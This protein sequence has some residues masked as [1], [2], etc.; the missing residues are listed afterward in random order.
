MSPRRK[1]RHHR[2]DDIIAHFCVHHLGFYICTR[3]MAVIWPEQKVAALRT[4]LE[5]EWLPI[6][7]YKTIRPKS[8][9]DIAI[10][11]GHIRSGCLV[12]PLGNF[13]SIRLTQLLTTE[14]SKA[15]VKQTTNKNWWSKHTIH[16]SNNILPDI[17][18]LYNMLGKTVEDQVVSAWTRPIGCIVPR[19]PTGHILSDAAYTGLGGWSPNYKFM[20]RLTKADL[21]SCGF[22]MQ[23]IREFESEPAFFN[24]KG[25][26]INLL[27]FV[28]IAINLWLAIWFI[29][30]DP[31]KPGGHVLLIEAD[32]TSALSW[33]RHS[34][35]CHSIPVR[36]RL[37]R[38]YI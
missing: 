15:G 22:N 21:E 26:H 19:D 31:N 28:A 24:E 4:L 35:R 8:P 25:L 16:I 30:K 10:L 11:L 27:E 2:K 18:M 13:M 5:T 17:T 1:I 34:A 7:P 33:L 9:K 38:M 36:N 20:W 37:R 3:R 29:K 6:P 14:M 32:N 12:F 23:R